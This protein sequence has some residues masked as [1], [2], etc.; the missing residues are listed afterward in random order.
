MC[1]TN[2]KICISSNEK[3][4]KRIV[5]TFE[6]KHMPYTGRQAAACHSQATVCL[7]AHLAPRWKCD[8]WYAD[9]W[10]GMSAGQGQVIQSMSSTGKVYSTSCGRPLRPQEPRDLR[11]A[12]QQRF[13][14]P[15]QYEQYAARRQAEQYATHQ[16]AKQYAAPRQQRYAAPDYP[17][18]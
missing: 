3:E 7:Q 2:K 10:P 17:Q 11:Q 13:V 6:K 4:K 1:F 9:V 8:D 12:K 5:Q 18:A 15:P 16:Q 14:P